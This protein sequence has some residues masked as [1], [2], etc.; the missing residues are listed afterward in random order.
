V[1]SATRETTEI[2]SEGEP[3]RFNAAGCL[4]LRWSYLAGASV[5]LGLIASNLVSP[6]AEV[7][8]PRYL[9]TDLGE[10]INAYGISNQGEVVGYAQIPKSLD[11]RSYVYR[12]G[13]K[14]LLPTLPGYKISGGNGIN[15]LGHV[16]VEASRSPSK[17]EKHGP[18][19][20]PTRVFLWRNGKM[21]DLGTLGGRDSDSPHMN[22]HDEV[23]GR[24]WTRRTF[25]A[26]LG[27]TSLNMTICRAFLWRDGR[28]RDLG[29]LG[30]HDS[31]AAGI[32]DRGQVV[33]TA[34]TSVPE[35]HAFLWENGRMRDLGTA[36]IK[37]AAFGINNKGE[38]VGVS[39]G[40]A[41]L[42]QQGKMTYLGSLGGR[43]VN[44][45][46][47]AIN[48]GGQVVGTAYTSTMETDP[49]PLRRGFL[50]REGR[51]LDLND[52]IPKETQWVLE[53]A[54]AI[55]DRGQIIAFGEKG[56]H[57]GTQ[58]HSLLLTPTLEAQL[59]ANT[60]W[61]LREWLS[62]NTLINTGSS[63]GGE[64]WKS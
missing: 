61:R 15:D 1:G 52:L 39:G 42:W 60:F 48:N 2:P 57:Q 8:L 53:G 38:V 26:K 36:G 56:D 4:R 24:S 30:G 35:E 44:G 37:S 3:A 7:A 21:R 27:I 5:L 59:A 50:Y 64:Q 54:W 9:V 40:R 6:A 49:H 41:V 20:W 14:Q 23:V 28:M 11:L 16:V 12:A 22:N 55:N 51:M 47:A 58:T 29:T 63:D 45:V 19:G 25:I 17:H 32:N 62:M 13:G 46:A 34:D 31:H 10:S 33:G 18:L 43:L